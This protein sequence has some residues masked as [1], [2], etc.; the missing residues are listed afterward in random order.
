M[1]AIEAIH[2]RRSVRAYRPDPVPRALIEE[3]LWA[4]VQAPSPPAS[5]DEPWSLCV[6]EGVERI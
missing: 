5:G 3:L 1:D 2:T 4:A 6:V